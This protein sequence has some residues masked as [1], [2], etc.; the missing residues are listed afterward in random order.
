MKRFAIVLLLFAMIFTMVGC[1]NTSESEPAQTS[2]APSASTTESKVCVEHDFTEATLL[3]PRECSECDTTEGEPLY[4]QCETWEDVVTCLYFD[5]MLYDLTV[6]EVDDGVILVLEFTDAN[7]FA[8]E[9]LL[10]EFM[11]KAFVSLPEII[12]FTQG[13]YMRTAVDTPEYFNKKGVT[14][15]LA[16]PGAA[17]GCI[18]YDG[19]FFGI[20]TCL[21]PD[22]GAADLT[23]LESVYSTAFGSTDVEYEVE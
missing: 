2:T 19:N 10:K 3:R 4:K 23:V 9:A 20:A 6:T 15:Y 11:V 17:I 7:Q 18:P 16:I 22:E 14:I 13:S 8:T 1:A 21:I 12:G 5:E